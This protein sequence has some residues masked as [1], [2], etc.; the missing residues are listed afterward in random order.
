VSDVTPIALVTGGAK[1]IGAACCRALAGEGFRVAVHHRSSGAAAEE[2][3]AKLPDAFGVCADL[4][5]PEAIDALVRELKERAGRIDVL[6]NN[7]GHNVNAP[8]ATMKL[9]DYDAVQSVAR[10]TWYLTK[11]VVRRFMLRQR[12]G[13]II[14]ISS[15]VG[16]TG[17]PGQIPY[18]MVKAGLDALTKSLG[19]EVAERGI[20][21]NAVAPGF[22]ETDMT[23][24][25]PAE[26]RDAILARIPLGRMG[27][28][29]DVAEAVRWLATAA[30][31]VQGS[32]LHVNG[33][34]HG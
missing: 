23:A 15:V 34:M 16:H 33:G 1:G 11:Q 24:E 2:L 29:E 22:I 20:F 3:V 32:V 5:E 8:M 12:S 19:Q 17:N 4:A 26:V 9:A 14:Q 7:A 18:T 28:P 31:Y 10:G 25:L 6:V 30:P 27:S 21:V 13:R